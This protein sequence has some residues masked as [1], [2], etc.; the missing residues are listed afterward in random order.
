VRDLV[1]NTSGDLDLVSRRLRLT[2]RGEEALAQKLR[3]R[4]SLA[5]GD[6]FLDTRVGV[7][8]YTDVMGKQP[9]GAVEAL[10]RGVIATC[11]GV[12]AIDRFVFTVDGATRRAT[13]SFAVRSLEGE[14]VNINDFIVSLSMPGGVLSTTAITSSPSAG[15]A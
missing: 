14:I 9:K 6:W 12:A 2:T 15:T 3:V 4:L 8:Y 5:Q 10:L 7:P 13:L 11:P 1:L